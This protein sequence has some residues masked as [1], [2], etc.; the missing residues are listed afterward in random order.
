[1][2]DPIHLGHVDTACAAKGALHLDEVRLIPARV[3]PHRTHGPLASRQHRLTMVELA[4]NGIEGLHASD[5]ELR[6]DD[7]SYTS[8]TL[9]RL[10]ATGLQ[11]WQLFFITGADA[12][13]EIATWRDYPEVLD[14]SHFVVVSRRGLRASDLVR[15][16]PDLATRMRHPNG[17]PRSLTEEPTRIWLID[18]DTHDISSSDIRN[19]LASNQSISGLVHV[20]V[21]AYISGKKLYVA[22]NTDGALHD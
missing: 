2:F 16:L 7:T 4:V 3:P 14:H 13:A 9:Q 18:H 20:A 12:F 22:G 11:P 10:G 17:P 15:R 5:I 8:L 19:R 21:D 1:M 6:S